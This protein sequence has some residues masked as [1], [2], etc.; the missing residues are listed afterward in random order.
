MKPIS[1]RVDEP[2]R[3]EATAV[4]DSMGM[5]LAAACRLFLTRIAEE[6]TFPMDLL[7]PSPER[8][9]AAKKRAQQTGD[10][11]QAA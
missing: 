9:E 5:T 2:T 7:T 10:V 6:K 4:L 3:L 11:D 1:I 8:I